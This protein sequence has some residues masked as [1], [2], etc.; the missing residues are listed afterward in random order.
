MRA[1]SSRNAENYVNFPN[2]SL[3]ALAECMSGTPTRAI[4]LCNESS[5]S[6]ADEHD[7]SGIEDRHQA[8]LPGCL[9]EN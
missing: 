5:L 7:K 8:A 6:R 9:V 4:A 3:L 2:L 1:K